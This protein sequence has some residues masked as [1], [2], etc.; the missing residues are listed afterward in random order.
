MGVDQY[1]LQEPGAA[2]RRDVKYLAHP[3]VSPKPRS[4]EGVEKAEQGC[5][6]WDASVEYEGVDGRVRI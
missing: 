2:Y 5:S 3:G 6:V 1:G 4:M